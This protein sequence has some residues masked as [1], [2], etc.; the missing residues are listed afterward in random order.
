MRRHE[1]QLKTMVINEEVERVI[2]GF[3]GAWLYFHRART[4]V[5]V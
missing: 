1:M 2:A 3:H 5:C 4:K